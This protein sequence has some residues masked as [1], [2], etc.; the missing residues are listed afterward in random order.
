[1]IAVIVSSSASYITRSLENTAEACDVL[2]D[3]K[4]YSGQ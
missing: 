2:T 4:I 3:R 1:M